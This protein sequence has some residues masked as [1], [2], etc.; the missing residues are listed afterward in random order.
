MIYLRLI[1]SFNDILGGLLVK[2]IYTASFH[3]GGRK[4]SKNGNEVRNPWQAC[5]LHNIRDPEYT[6][7]QRHIKQNG[8][9]GVDYE[10][11]ID[12]TWEQA[13][14]EIFSEAIEKYNAEQKRK[15]RK[16]K[17]AIEY[18]ERIKSHKTKV[19]VY[20]S[21]IS[22]GNAKNQVE[23][24]ELQKKI[25]KEFLENWRKNYKNLV[26]IGA[27]Y[28]ADESREKG[29]KFDSEGG[30]INGTPHLHIDWIPV[31]YNRQESF[32]KGRRK[33]EEGRKTKYLRGMDV[34]NNLNGAFAQM[35]IYSTELSPKAAAKKGLY[36]NEIK[37]KNQEKQKEYEQFL[38]CRDTDTREY[39]AVMFWE[40]RQRD[41]LIKL[42]EEHGLTIENPN[43]HRDHNDTYD[44]AKQESAKETVE[45]QRRLTEDLE[46]E[47]S[48]LEKSNEEL[49]VQKSELAEKIKSSEEMLIFQ[50]QKE[51]EL[52]KKISEIKEDEELI[53]AVRTET[54]QLEKLKSDTNL[55]IQTA[56]K[57]IEKELQEKIDATDNDNKKAHDFL[58]EA[59]SQKND[60]QEKLDGA[61]FYL[62]EERK[63]VQLAETKKLEER[64]KK[65][66]AAEDNFCDNAWKRFEKI[67]IPEA[68]D[69]EIK[70][71]FPTV[72]MTARQMYNEARVVVA[73]LRHFFSEKIKGLNSVIL[74]LKGKI[75]E[76][77]KDR[78][79]LA[80]LKK[81]FHKEWKS[82]SGENLT[83]KLPFGGKEAMNVMADMIYDWETDTPER[84][85]E[86]T[87]QHQKE[88]ER[89]KRIERSR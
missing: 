31:E 63:K 3:N 79:E 56:R 85:L 72:T 14:R 62:E 42:C 58:Q 11:W 78:D 26:I 51:H 52:S 73:K 9:E 66:K 7:K 84:N 37:Y 55:Q 89:N 17:D 35:K 83:L 86:K 33:N 32:D 77:Q 54:K 23:D 28:H 20:E 64:E 38:E 1:L 40:K 87:K 48:Q 39:Y 46:N 29:I 82:G 10:I 15:D 2:Q 22:V 19:P 25:Y 24:K 81:P 75:T 71:P 16:I 8:V 36:R 74:D 45:Y 76:L 41:T 44:Y 59:E 18:L 70:L 57:Q 5:R 50:K 65:I 34:E 47:K 13:Y 12:K 6:K 61:A 49:Q 68:E 60:A 67:V 69:I 30:R 27:Y 53:C 21:I 4:K 80:E 88:R 43:E